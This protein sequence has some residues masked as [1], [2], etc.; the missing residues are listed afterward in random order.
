MK[1]IF[2]WLDKKLIALYNEIKGRL[3]I[4]DD[5]V[6]KVLNFFSRKKH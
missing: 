2:I 6:S 4:N 3:G 1:A 5:F